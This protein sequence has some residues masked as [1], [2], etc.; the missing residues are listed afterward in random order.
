MTAAPDADEAP[1]MTAAPEAAE[2]LEAVVDTRQTSLENDAM[3]TTDAMPT[4][5][6]TSTSASI[7]A[8]GNEQLITQ[9]INQQLTELATLKK[10]LDALKEIYDTAS[11]QL[12]SKKMRE[13]L[14]RP[15]EET[16]KCHDSIQES[17]THFQQV[18]EGRSV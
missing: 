2:A 12:I 15:V 5:L 14:E 1:V 8:L 9:F 7:A 4:R 16:L 10:K 18:I 3:P 17:L 13:T 11:G 6:D